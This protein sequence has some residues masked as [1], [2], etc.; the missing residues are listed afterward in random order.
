M[1]LEKIR[2]TQEEIYKYHQQ[3]EKRA[4]ILQSKQK[5]L[6]GVI[7]DIESEFNGIKS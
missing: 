5:A 4:P 6:A 2:K 3:L 7:A 1:G